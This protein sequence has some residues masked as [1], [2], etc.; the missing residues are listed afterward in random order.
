MTHRLARDFD[1]QH[2]SDRAIWTLALA[3]KGCPKA[4]GPS[5]FDVQHWSWTGLD[6]TGLDWTGLDWTA[7][8]W[9]GL[10]I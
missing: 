7:L 1:I 6:W 10:Q 4:L 5:H 3:L 2:W 9:T 8:D